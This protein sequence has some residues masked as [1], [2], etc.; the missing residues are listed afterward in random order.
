MFGCC[1]ALSDGAGKPLRRG[2]Q[3]SLIGEPF[4]RGGWPIIA[5][6]LGACERVF[7]CCAALSDDAG[8]PLWRGGRQN[9]IGETNF[10]E[11][12][13]VGERFALAMIAVS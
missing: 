2:G 12:R 13:F 6:L 4:R 9:S 8:K 7:G 10:L 3:P 1:V 5:L 11:T